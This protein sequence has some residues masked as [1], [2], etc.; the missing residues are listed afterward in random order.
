MRPVTANEYKV[1]IINPELSL[2]YPS[3][4]GSTFSIYSRAP[5]VSDV[6]VPSGL[7]ED[8]R[9]QERGLRTPT[10]F[11]FYHFAGTVFS[12]FLS[13]FFPVDSPLVT[14]ESIPRLF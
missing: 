4:S 12:L 6:T 8:E 3:S 10:N 14:R 9:E 2:S 7:H 1:A 13:F 5:D 11:L